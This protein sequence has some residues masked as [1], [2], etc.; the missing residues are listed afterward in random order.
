MKIAITG[1][2]GFIATRLI[3]DLKKNNHEIVVIDK[4][5]SDPINILNQEKLNAACAGCDTIIH[6]AAAHRDDIFPRSIY[7]EENGVGTENV[8]KAAE[9]NDIKRIIFTST[10]AVYALDAGEPDESSAVDPFNDYGKSKLQAE[11]HIREWQNKS[12]DNIATIIRP[13]VVFGE[14][15]RGNVYNLIKQISDGKFLMIGRGD[16]KKSMAYVGNVALFIKHCLNEKESN[17]YNYADKP[18]LKTKELIDEIYTKLNQQKPSIVIPYWFGLLAGFGFDV[19]A[20]ITGKN[21]PVSSIRIKKFC[22]DT[23]VASIKKNQIGFIPEYSLTDGVE[24][25]INHDFKGAKT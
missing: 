13:V 9:I 19:L 14:N 6:L 16:N 24:R 8:T 18:D 10:V 15:N 5:H 20:K 11:E 3:E 25:M 4:A 2:S 1:G 23:S 12:P 21:F 17:L 22:A 7:Y